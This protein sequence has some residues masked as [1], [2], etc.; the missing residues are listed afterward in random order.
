MFNSGIL[1]TSRSQHKMKYAQHIMFCT[2]S[3]RCRIGYRKVLH[4]KGLVGINGRR[5]FRGGPLEM[6][7]SGLR[8]RRLLVCCWFP[9]AAHTCALHALCLVFTCV[10]VLWQLVVKSCYC[11]QIEAR[12]LDDRGKRVDLG[13]AS[14]HEA[15]EWSNRKT[16]S[17]AMRLVLIQMRY[18]YI[19]YR[20]RGRM[21]RSVCTTV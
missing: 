2:T 14:T 17:S 12:R 15:R 5:R 4:R 16:L 8:Y 1:S 9:V 10:L 11:D 7:E 20:E 19:P 3:T 18:S 21:R 6:I 13:D